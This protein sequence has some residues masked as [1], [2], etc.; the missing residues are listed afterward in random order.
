MKNGVEIYNY[1]TNDKIYY[2]PLETVNVLS[3]GSGYDVINPPSL[4]LSSGSALIQP[5]VKGCVEKIF[6]DPEDFDIDVVV[7]LFWV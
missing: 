4:T 1:K 7:W 3:G 5:V 6:V 2:G